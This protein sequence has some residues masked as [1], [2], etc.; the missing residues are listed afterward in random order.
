MSKLD[1][2]DINKLKAA[3]KIIEEIY[4]YNYDGYSGLSNRL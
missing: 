3:L 1:S 4:E 2:Y